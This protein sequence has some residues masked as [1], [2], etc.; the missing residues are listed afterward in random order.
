MDGRRDF[1]GGIVSSLGR[2]GAVLRQRIVIDF[3]E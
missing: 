2:M 1:R 3:G